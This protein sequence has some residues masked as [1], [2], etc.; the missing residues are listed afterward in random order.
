MMLKSRFRRLVLM[1]VVASV[2]AIGYSY[3]GGAGGAR[4]AAG[5]PPPH[6]NCPFAAI[7]AALMGPHG[8]AREAVDT[9]ADL[10][11]AEGALAAAAGDCPDGECVGGSARAGSFGLLTRGDIQRQVTKTADGVV[12]RISSKK[13]AVVKLIQDRFEPTSARDASAVT[14]VRASAGEMVRK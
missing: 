10:F 9:D 14:S 13:P 2:G 8:T 12:I 6:G 3:A 11:T 4:R 1:A 7:R 5:A